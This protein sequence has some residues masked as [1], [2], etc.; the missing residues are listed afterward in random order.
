[1]LWHCL[2]IDKAKKDLPLGVILLTEYY[3]QFY[4][5]LF[6]YISPKAKFLLMQCY[7]AYAEWYLLRK[8]MCE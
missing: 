6:E 5:P 4:S 8:L 3:A 2:S 1:M 7:S